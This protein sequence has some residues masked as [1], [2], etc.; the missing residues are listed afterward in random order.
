MAIILFYLALFVFGCIIGSF[1][2]V[3][4][5]RGETNEQVVS[6]RSYCDHCK[7]SLN[8]VDLVPVISFIS[9]GGKCRYCKYKLSYYYPIVELTTGFLFALSSFQ[10][11]NTATGRNIELSGLVHVPFLL[12]IIIVLVIVF[13]ADVKYGIIPLKAVIFGV[14]ISLFW[15]QFF[16]LSDTT[17]FNYFLSG[18]FSFLSF[19]AIHLITKGKGMGMGDVIFVFLMGLLLGFP[20]IVIGFY[21]AFI[22]GAIISLILIFLK[23]KKMKGGT[24]PF[25][26][27]LVAGTY[28][29]LLWGN[30]ILDFIIAY[31]LR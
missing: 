10:I 25:G 3:L 11:L 16:P 24:I 26:P 14:V 22:S 7:K 12:G 4:I 1:I 9:L 2:N 15:N 17:L 19:L 18:I 6:G 27:F 5:D 28:I 30:N 13:F 21:I 23:K 29:S 20:K 31:L 8:A